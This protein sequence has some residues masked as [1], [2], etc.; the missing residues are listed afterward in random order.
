MRNMKTSKTLLLLSIAFLG[1]PLAGCGPTTNASSSQNGNSSANSGSASQTSTQAS[2]A[3][4]SQDAKVVASIKIYGPLRKT[5]FYQGDTVDY[6]KLAIRTYN[7]ANT[8]IATIAY[9]GHESDFTYVPFDTSAVS[10]ERT[11]SVTYTDPTS[12]KT[13]TDSF[14]YAVLENNLVPAQWTENASWTAFN[15]SLN[16]V[17]S[18]KPGFNNGQFNNAF[19]TKSDFYVG[20]KNSINLFPV[21][22]GKKASG[23]DSTLSVMSSVDRGITVT[24]KDSLG[25]VLN[26]SDY[27]SETA[28]N[29]LIKKGVVDFNDDK[30]GVFNLIFTYDASTDKNAFPDILYKL[31]IV[32]G[33]NVSDSKSLAIMYNDDRSTTTGD[34][35]ANA[36]RIPMIEA[37]KKANNI[38]TGVAVNSVV[39]QKDL[40]INKAD[41][42][43][44]YVWGEG[45]DN[46]P[47]SDS[48]KGTLKDWEFIYYHALTDTNPNFNLYGNYHKISCGDDF[49]YVE[50]SENGQNGT[51]PAEGTT[52]SGHTCLF[53][54]WSRYTDY[55]TKQN[56]KYT[57]QDLAFT[58][59]TGVSDNKTGVN[60]STH[61]GIIFIKPNYDC[62][63][64]N[65]VIN[66]VFIGE[67]N[68]GYYN[69]KSDYRDV[70]TTWNNTRVHDTYSAMLFNWSAGTIAST[71]CEFAHCG[72]PIVIN[73][74]NA[75]PLAT[76][77][78]DELAGRKGA[79][80][81]FD[82]QTVLDNYVSGT[83]G[84]FDSYAGA[85]TYV[86]QLKGMNPL[87][88]AGIKKTFL[89]S[90][91][92]L[93]LISVNMTTSEGAT[94][95]KEGSLDGGTF[96]GDQ[97]IINYEGGKDTL[98]AGV[99]AAAGG[100]QG[101]AFAAALYSTDIGV[102]L[103]NATGTTVKNSDG[104][105]TTTA[106]PF[107]KFVG[108]TSEQFGMLTVGTDGQV[109][110]MVNAKYYVTQQEADKAFTSDISSAKYVGV[111][112]FGTGYSDATATP[113]YYHGSWKGCNDFG[114]VFSISDYKTE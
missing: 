92:K 102:S 61:C 104:T 36:K 15:A 56:F 101:A 59:K 10:A 78:A 110:G 53:G 7:A 83:G 4:S 29:D 75:T 52:I 41:L 100:D 55:P 73:Q 91:N 95:F 111:Y 79:W 90:E 64:D 87:L 27:F 88:E 30:T 63:I 112:G 38:P 44:Y 94:S 14:T 81:K 66:S 45:E 48:M 85:T 23:T 96:I 43:T 109:N 51:A 84:W 77:A 34:Y 8:V 54:G 11:F 37:W 19:M 26:L 67:V 72:G 106:N 9:S 103:M 49:P 98:D 108:D 28:Q 93:N 68:G 32:D 21:V 74:P 42:P 65:C 62:D 113:T 1:L 82:K 13:F 5:S 20:N 25:T 39:V 50:E 57:I 76:T 46:D 89:D 31:H 97:K 22:K 18:T 47:V 86:A 105:S 12:K 107:F 40:V 33:Y 114:L 2:S 3:L 58:G 70:T 99:V 24:L 35:L 16:S 71:N 6:A 60:F 69:N 80:I 17:S